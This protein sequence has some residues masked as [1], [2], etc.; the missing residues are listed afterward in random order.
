MRTAALRRAHVRRTF[1]ILQHAAQRLASRGR[2]QRLRGG[3]SRG[4]GRVAR[5]SRIRRSRGRRRP[6]DY[7]ICSPEVPPPGRLH[8]QAGLRRGRG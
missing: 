6:G 2:A 1:Q 3:A 5:P 7:K 8:M 4:R